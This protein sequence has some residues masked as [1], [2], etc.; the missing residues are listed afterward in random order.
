MNREELEASDHHGK[1]AY[2]TTNE[3]HMN[4]YRNSNIIEGKENIIFSEL[5]YSTR[6]SCVCADNMPPEWATETI[7][8]G[9][10][11]IVSY[12]DFESDKHF[13]GYADVDGGCDELT[14]GEGV[15]KKSPICSLSLERGLN[16]KQFNH[17]QRV[18]GALSDKCVTFGERDIIELSRAIDEN[19]KNLSETVPAYGYERYGSWLKC[20]VPSED[21]RFTDERYQDILKKNVPSFTPHSHVPVFRLSS[22]TILEISC[23]KIWKYSRS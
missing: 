8:D 12:Y 14:C 10:I 2:Y 5:P 3:N 17:T 13:A 6:G 22:K 15:Q 19:G 7:C 18:L 20:N 9:Y 11:G 1:I 4:L 23:R 21:T 16:N